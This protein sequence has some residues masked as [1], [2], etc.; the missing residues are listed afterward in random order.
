MQEGY[1]KK[2]FGSFRTPLYSNVTCFCFAYKKQIVRRLWA[3]AGSCQN[4]K[5]FSESFSE[6][7]EREREQK[8]KHVWLS[9][10]RKARNLNVYSMSQK[11][12]GCVI[13]KPES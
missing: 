12:S 8:S 6:K 1:F 4:G 2:K 10:K 3:S 11:V 7:Q 9:Q 5:D 13:K